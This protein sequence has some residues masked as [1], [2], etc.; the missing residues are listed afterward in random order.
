MGKD[1]SD[2]KDKKE[3]KER[4]AS[5]EGVSKSTPK[6]EKKDKKS[7][8]S[9]VTDALLDQLEN[10]NAAVAVVDKDGDVEMDGEEV[11]DGQV[12]VA[13]KGALVPFANPLAEDKEAKKVMK[14]VKKGECGFL[15]YLISRPP[16]GDPL[17]IRSAS[18]CCNA[19]EQAFAFASCS[20]SIG[21]IPSSYTIEYPR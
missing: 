10:G 19:H 4:R 8:K 7:R 18:G 2:K 3:K 15:C 11:V 21:S 12:V 20:L 17:R 16:W 6:K 9:D 14:G 1:K 13:V 5:T